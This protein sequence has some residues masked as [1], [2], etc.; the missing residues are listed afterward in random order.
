MASAETTSAVPWRRCFMATAPPMLSNRPGY[1][2]SMRHMPPHVIF[3]GDVDHTVGG[4][5]DLNDMA[6]VPIFDIHVAAINCAI[7]RVRQLEIRGQL[8]TRL[9]SLDEFRCGDI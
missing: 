8:L 3:R 2:G 6:P 5:V 9:E 4:G 7:Q 1:E